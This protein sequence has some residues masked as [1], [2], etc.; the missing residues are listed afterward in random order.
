MKHRICSLEMF[1]FFAIACT[2]EETSESFWPPNA[3]STC[4][5]VR[6]RLARALYLLLTK[7]KFGGCVQILVF[8]Q[9]IYDISTVC[10][11]GL[12]T[13]SIHVERIQISDAPRKQKKSIW[14]RF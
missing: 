11:T 2:C 6:I 3:S 7:T 12:E 1:F 9:A 5:Y 4:S 10:L 14:S 13:I 8:P